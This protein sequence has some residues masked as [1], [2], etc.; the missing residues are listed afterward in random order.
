M[1]RFY[2][3]N[4][5]IDQ[6]LKWDRKNQLELQ[7]KFQ[8]R[9]VWEDAARSYLID[10]IVR[11]LPMPKIYLRRTVSSRTKLMTYEAVDGQQRLQ[12]ILDF[13][14]GKLVLNKSH[15]EHLGGVTFEGLPEPVQRSFLEYQISTEVMEDA[16]DPEVWGMFERLNTYTLTLNAQ[17]RLNAKYFGFFK[18]IAYKLAAEESAFDA[19]HKMR[20][21]TNR[22]IARMK[23]V[24]FTSDVLVAIVKG[25]S[26]LT[27]IRRA[28]GDLDK[29]FPGRKTASETFQESLNFIT[30]QIGDAVGAS[31]FRNRAWFYSLMVALAD[32][33]S[34]I[35]DG[36]GPK[37]LRSGI[38]IQKRM[39]AL[40]HEL[41]LMDSPEGLAE[42]KLRKTPVALAE[43]HRVLSR[44]TSH[45]PERKVRHRYFFDL[46]TVPEGEWGK[47]LEP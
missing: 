36:Y 39:F 23:E 46:L 4:Y 10:T 44:A 8:R 29:E 22:Q 7:P 37:K 40:D 34:E 26:D 14:K 13:Y 43:L 35:P 31:R 32:A 25:I 20:I 45:A 5:N 38:E 47:I 18:Q 28:Y 19:W 6:F 16:T 15:N 24:E 41:G 42:L 21:F 1:A 2:R 27:E 9:G 11:G 12:A 3:E 30:S 17:E 33:R